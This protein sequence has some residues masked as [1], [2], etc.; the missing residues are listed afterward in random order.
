MGSACSFVCMPP[1][2]LRVSSNLC[3]QTV[4]AHVQLLQLSHYRGRAGGER[5][6]LGR[7]VGKG[8]LFT[9]RVSPNVRP[10]LTLSFYEAI[11]E[12][13]KLHWWVPQ[14]WPPV[15]LF[16][17]WSTRSNNANYWKIWDANAKQYCSDAFWMMCV[18]LCCFLNGQVIWKCTQWKH[19]D[20]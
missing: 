9:M 1:S 6:I 2:V 10:W 4:H 7:S 16:P 5:C 11:K 14:K 8:A 18:L 19:Y 17:A 20:E 15:L 12:R 13:A 3:P